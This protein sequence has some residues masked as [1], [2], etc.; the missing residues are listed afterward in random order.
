MRIVACQFA[1]EGRFERFFVP[2]RQTVRVSPALIQL[3]AA[4]D[5]AAALERIHIVVPAPPC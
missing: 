5:V 4:D 2:V 1:L 3:S